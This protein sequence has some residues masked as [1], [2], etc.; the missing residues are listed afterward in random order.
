VALL[1]FGVLYS[2]AVVLR[3]MLFEAGVLSTVRVG[4]PVIAVGNI[5]AGGT[6]KTPLVE[7]IVRLLQTNGQKVAV[8]SRGYGRRSQGVVVV[9]DGKSVLVDGSVGGDEP[10]QVA[11]KFSGVTVV[12][13]ERR[14]E[15]ARRAVQECGAEVIVLDDAFQHRFVHR[16]LNILVLEAGK[17]VREER[18]LPAG[19]R[20]EP[21]AGIRRADLVAWSGIRPHLRVADLGGQIAQWFGGP[22]ISYCVEPLPLVIARGTGDKG[23]CLRKRVLA[24]C[25]IAAPERFFDMI[26]HTGGDTVREMVF[27]DHHRFSIQDVERILLEFRTSHADLMVTTEKDVTRMLAAAEVKENFLDPYPVWY[28]PVAV[29]IIEGEEQLTTMLLQ[30]VRRRDAR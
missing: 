22:M 25:G 9:S 12:V 18:S 24:F 15:A 23:S 5:T 11:R 26:R 30:V 20:R 3:N 19:L 1:P 17:R 2:A 29:R 28:L 14:I 27:P 4:V 7:Y 6:G 13:G 21:L 16:D 8:V 10:V